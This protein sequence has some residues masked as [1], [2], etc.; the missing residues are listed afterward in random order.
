MGR[1][2]RAH[3]REAYNS[4]ILLEHLLTHGPASIAEEFQ[5]DTVAITE[6]QSFEHVDERGCV[7]PIFDS[8]VGLLNAD[9]FFSRFCR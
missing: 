6:L 1:F 3:W 7:A 8:P 5:A 2:D 4:L 9:W